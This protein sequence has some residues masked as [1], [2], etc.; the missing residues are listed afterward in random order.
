MQCSVDKASLNRTDTAPGDVVPCRN[1]DSWTPLTMTVVSR[2]NDRVV[3][4]STAPGLSQ[5][6]AGTVPSGTDDSAAGPAQWP[7]VIR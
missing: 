4:Q 5:F 1:A 3:Y 7:T 6:T 2:G